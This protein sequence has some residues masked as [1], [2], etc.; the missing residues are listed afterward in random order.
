[1]DISIITVN[2]NSYDFAKLLIESIRNFTLQ[3]YEIIL[4]DNSLYKQPIPY[5]EVVVLPQDSNIGH[6][7]GLNIGV[8]AAQSPIVVFFDIDCHV[9][10][11][12]WERLIIDRLKEVDVIGGRGVE[13]KPIR[14][15]F[16]AMKTSTALKYDFRPTEGY[17]GH[18]VTPEGFDVAISAYHKMTE[19][20]ILI[21]LLDSQPNR[22]H[23][24]NG[25]EWLID[26]IPI[27]YHHWHGSHLKE[28]QVDFE[29]DLIEDKVHLFKKLRKV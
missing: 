18:R 12:Y 9:L 3:S 11:H 10:S 27:C 20:G 14:P 29:E 25:E 22:Y 4:V 5:P 16:M 1:M 6:G 13:A 23:T 8:K 7:E 28:R 15:A 24:L 21:E 26:G 2:Y 17:Q 19:D